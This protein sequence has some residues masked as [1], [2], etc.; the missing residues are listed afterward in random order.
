MKNNIVDVNWL[1]DNLGN[2]NLIILDATI[3][4]AT[5][6]LFEMSTECIPGSLFFDLKNV[7]SEQNKPFPNTVPSPDLFEENAQLL[8]INTDSVVVVYDQHGVYSSPRAWW[9]FK[10]MGHKN[11]FVLNGGLPEWKALKLKIQPTFSLSKVK[12]NFQSKLKDQFLKSKENVLEIINNN[13]NQ[14][15]DAR[16]N[17]RFLGTEPEPR[18]GLRAGH[19]PNSKNL[20][21]AKLTNGNKLISTE[22]IRQLFTD[23]EIN[24]K[25]ITYSC[26]SGITACILALAGT[27][28]NITDF[29]I[30]DGSWTEW[31]SLKELPIEK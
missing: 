16:S 21:Y 27:Q 15:I 29:S 2:E 31:G 13:S 3:P 10:L 12:G 23:L 18:Q 19:I 20:H 4:K 30:Y 5:D 14:I 11:V 6:K 7:F 17:K 8:G 28:I 25:A 22:E 1:K 26:G 9:L 24:K